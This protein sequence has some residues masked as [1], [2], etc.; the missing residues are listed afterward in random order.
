MS[1]SER[2]ASFQTSESQLPDSLVSMGAEATIDWQSRKHRTMDGWSK[3]ATREVGCC[4]V[5]VLSVK[6]VLRVI[7]LQ[8]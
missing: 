6:I 8:L 7:Y 5:K 4:L 2:A 1:N 3:Q